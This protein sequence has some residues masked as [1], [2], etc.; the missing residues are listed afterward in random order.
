MGIRVVGRELSS[1]FIQ[2]IH[3]FHSQQ[4]PIPVDFTNSLP[5]PLTLLFIGRQAFAKAVARFKKT[6]QL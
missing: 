3:R 6:T 4:L 2:I 1:P 5:L